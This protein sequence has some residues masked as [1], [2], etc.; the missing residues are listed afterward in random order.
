M[1]KLYITNSHFDKAAYVVA[2]YSMGI[3]A[4]THPMGVLIDLDAYR[5]NY[6][7]WNAPHM[8]YV[9]HQWVKALY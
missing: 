2:L 1:K 7:G 3:P 8:V 5:A 4:E 9:N 6:K